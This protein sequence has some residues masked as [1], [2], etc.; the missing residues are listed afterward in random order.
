MPQNNFMHSI[1]ARSGRPGPYQTAYLN[2]VTAAGRSD[3]L[4]QRSIN[5][6]GHCNFTPAEL[7]TAF[8]DLVVWAEYGVKPAP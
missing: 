7:G 6:Y 8:T 2:L 3:L 5:R 4:V 1:R